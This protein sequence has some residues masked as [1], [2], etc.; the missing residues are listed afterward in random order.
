MHMYG[1]KIKRVAEALHQSLLLCVYQHSFGIWNANAWGDV[2]HRVV[3]QESK[4]HLIG[5]C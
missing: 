3:E 2:D 4:A 5:S 1:E